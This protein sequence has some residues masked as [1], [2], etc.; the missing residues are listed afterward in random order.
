MVGRRRSERF[1]SGNSL[2][3]FAS[4]PK[5]TSVALENAYLSWICWGFHLLR[6]IS[7]VSRV[8]FC[9]CLQCWH[10]WVHISSSDPCSQAQVIT[11]NG[12]K[13]K[14]FTFVKK[15][16]TQLV[17]KQG[18]SNLNPLNTAANDRPT[19]ETGCWEAGYSAHNRYRVLV[20]VWNY[21]LCIEMMI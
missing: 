20:A 5:K 3:E 9:C 6:W 16:R 21:S 14:L 12:Q 13:L 2:W 17:K 15:Y 19:F 1:S 10:H 8:S 11:D 18:G 4:R 7:K